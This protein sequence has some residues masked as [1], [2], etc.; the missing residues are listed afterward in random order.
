MSMQ[1]VEMPMDIISLLNLSS[2]N[3]MDIV[4]VD[5]VFTTLVN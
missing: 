4:K 3:P 1:D 5:K 2:Y